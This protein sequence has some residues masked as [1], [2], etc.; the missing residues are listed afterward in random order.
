[1]ENP[2]PFSTKK[3]PYTTIQSYPSKKNFKLKEKKKITQ[4]VRV[5]LTMDAVGG[6][7]LYLSL[8]WSLRGI[9]TAVQ[10]PKKFRMLEKNPAKLIFFFQIFFNFFFSSSNYSSFIPPKKKGD[11][12]RDLSV[13]TIPNPVM[14]LIFYLMR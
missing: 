2:A 6:R 13:I 9:Q 3:Q 1:M 10:Q 7:G 5:R 11:P 4:R 8:I 14:L 12:K